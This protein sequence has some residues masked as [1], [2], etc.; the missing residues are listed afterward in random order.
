LSIMRLVFASR[1]SIKNGATY[2][3]T[4]T[5][6]FLRCFIMSKWLGLAYKVNAHNRAP[7]MALHTDIHTSHA[8]W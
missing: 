4:S 8:R 6:H 1:L 3:T 7:N 2:F 5:I